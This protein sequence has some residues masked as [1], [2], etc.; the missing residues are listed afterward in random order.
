MDPRDR[1]D[2]AYSVASLLFFFRLSLQVFQVQTNLPILLVTSQ[3][4]GNVT[5][6]HRC[7]GHLSSLAWVLIFY[8]LRVRWSDF[9]WAAETHET[10]TPRAIT[11]RI[12][13]IR[14]MAKSSS[15]PSSPQ[16]KSE[17]SSRTIKSDKHAPKAA[18]S[19]KSK[20][21]RADATAEPK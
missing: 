20:R 3:D 6:E 8:T 14:S 17:A 15:T 5:S 13:K 4:I 19:P 11:E 9:F 2:C 18:G 16:R 12:H 21:K 7:E 10:P 1:S